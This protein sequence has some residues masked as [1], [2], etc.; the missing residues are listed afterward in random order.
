MRRT[1]PRCTGISRIDEPVPFDPTATDLAIGADR[2]HGRIRA[3][4]RVEGAR[5]GLGVLP[6]ALHVIPTFTGIGARL[7]FRAPAVEELASAP[8]P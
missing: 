2:R 6:N 8:S 4:T 3:V 5:R 1:A 7:R